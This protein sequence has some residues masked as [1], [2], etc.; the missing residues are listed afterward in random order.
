[1]QFTRTSQLP[2]R[3][4][5]VPTSTPSCTIVSKRLVALVV[6]LQI[7]IL[8]SLR[9]RAW[10]CFLSTHSISVAL[11]RGRN[12]SLMMR[13][14]QKSLPKQRHLPHLCSS[15]MVLAGCPSSA[16]PCD[17][18]PPFVGIWLLIAILHCLGEPKRLPSFQL[19][20]FLATSLLH[21]LLDV[22]LH[23]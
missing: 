18:L 9:Q 3:G 11:E 21:K 13:Q 7:V 14:N 16:K 5:M 12:P 20:Q 23:T 15:W 1:M 22:Y 8:H 6:L 19:N 4:R 17:V 2:L 10:L